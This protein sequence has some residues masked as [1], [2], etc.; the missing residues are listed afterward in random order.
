MQTVFQYEAFIA[1]SFE[2]NYINE[3]EDTYTRDIDDAF[4]KTPDLEKPFFVAQMG[5]R[6]AEASQQREELARQHALEAEAKVKQLE[7]EKD[8]AWKTREKKRQE[9]EAARLR[10][11]QDSKHIR[12]RLKQAKKRKKK[13]KK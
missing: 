5:W 6:R 1:R 9:Q 4:D 12:K 2:P 11:L 8:K 7:S 10:N 13:K 3:L